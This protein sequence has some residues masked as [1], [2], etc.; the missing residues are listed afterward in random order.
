MLAVAA[1]VALAFVRGEEIVSNGKVVARGEWAAWSPSGRVAVVRDGWIFVDGRRRYRGATPAWSSRGELAY[2]RDRSLWVGR[3]R[4]TRT[5][6]QWQQDA[7]PTWSP[8]GK[9]IAFAAM[10]DSALH[11]ELWIV[12]RD[13]SRLRRLTKTT[14]EYD[15]GMPSFLPDGRIVFVSTRDKNRELYVW[16]RGRVRRLT[17]T[18]RI[19]ESLPKVS[20][21]GRRVAFDTPERRVGV[22]TVATGR[23]RFVARGSAPAW[24]RP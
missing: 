8:D 3:R 2:V 7:L 10:R 11:G 17:H 24:V 20:P 5:R 16:S 19:D 13:G 15:D 18:A 4:V 12:A 22:Y 1:V 21:D 23:E 14:A 9:L 6:F